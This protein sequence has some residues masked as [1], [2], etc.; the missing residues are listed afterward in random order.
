MLDQATEKLKA[1]RIAIRDVGL[2]EGLQSHTQVLPTEV[3]VEIF[4]GLVAAGIREIN[5]V[6]FVNPVKMPHMG[7]P[8]DLLRSLG[9]ARDG[10]EISGVVLSS[11]GLK[12]ALTM[13]KEGLLDLIFLVYSPVPGTMASN[14]VAG[15]SE[16]LLKKMQD[17]AAE[18]AEAGLKVGTFC[19]ETFG[20]P[21][22]GWTDPELV[23][24][25][26]SRLTASPGVTELIISDTTGQGDPL[27]VLRFFTALSRTQPVDRRICYHVH[28]SRGSGLA[29]I[30]AALCSPFRNFVLDSSF[31]GYGGD[32]PFVPDAFGNVATEDL[33][34]MLYGMGFRHGV[35]PD[36]ITEITKKY[37]ALTNRPLSARLGLTSGTLK[38]KR[39]P[40]HSPVLQ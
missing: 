4:K 14:G 25:T 36:G 1:T 38:W 3:K 27:Q 18:A 22:D 13:R 29:N 11:S 8:E 31:G 28:D 33:A 15:D 32:F 10:I 37:V 30:F 23:V 17:M 35:D 20:S 24:E 16:E 12:R 39:R 5:A 2:R 40:E 7:D 19:S 9:S 34:E 21:T 26:A 6:A